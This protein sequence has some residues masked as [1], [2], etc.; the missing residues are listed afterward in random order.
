MKKRY[1]EMLQEA[2]H[3]EYDP[4]PLGE[5]KIRPEIIEGKDYK[6][7]ITLYFVKRILFFDEQMMWQWNPKHTK[8]EMTDE[9]NILNLYNQTKN[10]TQTSQSKD[11]RQ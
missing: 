2:K 5:T 1:E 7:E 11:A 6:F 9:T 3:Y 8:W 4:N 10:T